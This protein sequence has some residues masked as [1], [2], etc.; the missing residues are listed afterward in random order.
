MHDPKK[1]DTAVVVTKLPNKGRS[2][3]E[4]VERRAGTKENAGSQSMGRTQSRGTVSQ[5]AERIRQ[6]IRRD[7]KKRLTALLHHINPDTLE[8]A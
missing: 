3:A 7:P 4:A 6:A 8:D 5:A 1:S 2:P